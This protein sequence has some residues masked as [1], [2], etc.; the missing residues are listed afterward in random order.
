M[1]VIKSS[2]INI[3]S[4]FSA[5]KKLIS[6]VKRSQFFL[7]LVIAVTFVGCAPATQIEK[8]WREPGATVKKEGSK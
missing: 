3:K 4:K 6:S 8:S 1:L 5:M 7:M 2:T